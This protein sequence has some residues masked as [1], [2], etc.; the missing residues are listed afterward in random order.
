MKKVC[1]NARIAFCGKK[2]FFKTLAGEKVI[3][4]GC[5]ST[6]DRIVS[7]A[8]FGYFFGSIVGGH[9]NRIVFVHP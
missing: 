6:N 2:F 4:V 8:S 5:D 3:A 9:V 1:R 7:N